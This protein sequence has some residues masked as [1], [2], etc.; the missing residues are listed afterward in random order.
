MQEIFQEMILK[1]LNYYL[2]NFLNEKTKVKLEAL[3]QIAEKQFKLANFLQEIGTFFTNICDQKKVVSIIVKDE[4]SYDIKNFLKLEQMFRNNI[5]GQQD[6]VERLHK[7]IKNLKLKAEKK[8]FLESI[9]EQTQIPEEYQDPIYGELIKDPVMLPQSKTI[10]D[11]KVIKAALLEK[12]VDPYT[13]TPLD[14][15]DLIPQPEL[16]KKIEEW[17]NNLKKQRDIKVEE[18]DKN[19][20][21]T[22]IPFKQTQSFNIQEEE[23]ENVFKGKRYEEGD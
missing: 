15:K 2:N 19:R 5:A 3:K 7:F 16:K 17:L 11:R 10:M 8:Q 13:L 18:A 21:Q 14:E 20:M 6:K 4:R 9:L 1:M 12:K 22:E 23:E